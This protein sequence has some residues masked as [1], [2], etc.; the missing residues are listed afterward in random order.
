MA[1]ILAVAAYVPRYR[2][3]REVIAKE[4]GAVPGPGERAVANHDEDSLTMAVNAA[5]ALPE[6][7]GRPGAIFFA[8]TSPP[9]AEKQGAA[10]IAAVLDLAPSTRTLDVGSTLRAGTSAMLAAIDAVAGG[11]AARVVVAAAECRLAEP[12][13]AAEQ[14]FGDGAA[15]L[16][17]GADPGI[18]EVVAT[19][20][21]TEDLLG[22]W[23]TSAQDFTHTFPS[24]FESK[25]GYSRLL[26]AAAKAA[27]EKAGMSAADL[28]VAI[29]PAPNPRAPLAVAKALGLDPRRQLADPLWTTVGDTG[30]AQPLMM[31]AAALDQ[32][33]AGDAILL[34][35]Y[36]DGAD[37]IVLRATGAPPAA[38]A[39]V[40]QQVEV[41][42]TLPS[43][44]RYARFRRL[45]RKDPG[46]G[47]VSS[48]VITFRDR[49][50]I[51]PLRGGKCPACGVVQFPRHRA[52][53]EC[54]HSGGLED[55]ALGRRGTLFTFTNDHMFESPDP[56]T[57]HGVVDLEGGGR[58]YLQLTDCDADRVAIGMP[59]ELTFR[60]LH[61]GG[62]FHNYFWKARPA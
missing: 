32:A 59:L 24:A 40:A 60:R 41:K 29:L 61:D 44:G 55:V 9:Y 13:S 51:L 12:E 18:A 11:A 30:V 43:Y 56:P 8:T 52:C 27:L 47:D 1:G 62:G 33:N 53:I 7:G 17:I 49:G 5:T 34:C 21:V 35:G 37:A 39:S 31:L 28:R 45:M 38:R 22:T 54:G 57:T 19:H 50:E 42:R 2:L 10:T 3:P 16:L 46:L 6:P 25:L 14:S 23:R 48:P 26:P 4:W 15:A 58:I 36:G 20:T